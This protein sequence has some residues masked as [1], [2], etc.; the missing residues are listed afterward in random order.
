MRYLIVFIML[1]MVSTAFANPFTSGKPNNPFSGGKPPAEVNKVEVSKQND[2]YVYLVDK[3]RMIRG[4]ITAEFDKIKDKPFSM[5]YMVFLFLSF[6]YGAFHSLGPGH[7]KTLVSGYVLSSQTALLRSALF[8]LLVAFGHAFVAFSAVAVIFY[9]LESSV[10]GGFDS[11][12]VILSNISYA[13]ILFVG[14]LMFYKKLRKHKHSHDHERGFFTSALLIS[15][16]PCPGA[17]VLTMFAFSNGMPFAGFMSVFFMAMGMTVTISG[18]AVLT[19]FFKSALSM[20]GRYEKIYGAV[21]YAGILLLVS[22]ST[23]M[24]I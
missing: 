4:K 14:L 1:L 21:E 7:A 13:T 3:Q 5:S 24:L 6:A 8:G 19:Y 16:V 18:V 17:M 9:V 12:S 20:S 11:A 23:L 10:T 15:L 2:F 22:F